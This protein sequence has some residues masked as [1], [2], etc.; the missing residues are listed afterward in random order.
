ML[1]GRDVMY[2]LDTKSEDAYG[3]TGQSFNRQ[4]AVGVAGRIPVII[5]GGLNPDNVA[6]V[7]EEVHPW[8]VDVSS[9]VETDGQKDMAKIKNFISEVKAVAGG[10]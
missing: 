2:L 4:I 6:G 7:V 9:G 3:G 5:A 1:R 10:G 8:G